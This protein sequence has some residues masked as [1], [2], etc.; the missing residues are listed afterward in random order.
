M[1]DLHLKKR[2]RGALPL[3]DSLKVMSNVDIT[4]QGLAGHTQCSAKTIQKKIR[5]V[6]LGRAS[7]LPAPAKD[8][9]CVNN[10]EYLLQNTP[11]LKKH[12]VRK[13]KYVL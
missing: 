1:L 7:E 10:P 9:L 5:E 8:T 4:W 2:L 12:H 11:Q 3:A 6:A 13:P